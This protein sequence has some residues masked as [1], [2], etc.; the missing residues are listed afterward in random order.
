VASRHGFT[1]PALMSVLCE[2]RRKAGVLPP[3]Q[4]KSV[5]F[6]DRRLWYALHSLGFPSDTAA[7]MPN[8]RV[9]AIGARDHWAAECQA[10]R[11]LLVPTI[12]HAV[13]AIRAALLAAGNEQTEKEAS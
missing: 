5:K 13:L 3:A 4:F 1:T 9:E 10:G 12:D 6:V 2:A 7:P 11:P 8:P